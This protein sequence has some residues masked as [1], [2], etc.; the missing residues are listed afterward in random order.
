M[1]K[2]KVIIA[3]ALL[4]AICLSLCACGISKEKA[5]GNWTSNYEYKGNSF[6]HTI[7][8]KEDGTYFDLTLKNG[9]FSSAESGTYEIKLG[10]V[11][12][13]E[14]G[15]KSGY[16]ELKYKFGKLENGGHEYEKIAG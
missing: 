13:Y 3:V 2:C 16:M 7:V 1:K 8:L 6:K 12:L 4:C 5:V 14:D 11:R 10:K 15:D 9:R